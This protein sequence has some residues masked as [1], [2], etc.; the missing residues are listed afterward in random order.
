MVFS[1]VVNARHNFKISDH[2][3][4]RLFSFSVVCL[5]GFFAGYG[6]ILAA[7]A[8]GLDANM[9]KIASLPVVFIMQYVLNSRITFRKAKA[10]SAPEGAV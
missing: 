9:G 7:Q 8:A 2:M 3:L 5:I 4:L 1:F 6:V 10:P